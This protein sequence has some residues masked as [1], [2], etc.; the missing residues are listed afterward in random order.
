MAL[1]C[2]TWFIT[3]WEPEPRCP[4]PEGSFPVPG[5]LLVG[6]RE[7][8]DTFTLVWLNADA[9]V[10]SIQEIALGCENDTQVH[11]WG[12]DPI[13]CKVLVTVTGLKGA[14]IMTGTLKLGSPGDGSAGTFAAE[15]SAPPP[16]GLPPGKP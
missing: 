1:S 14:T 6:Q 8:S 9:K 3:K 15:A 2:K 16:P 11:F 12:Q 13:P 7:G 4:L 5:C 10:C